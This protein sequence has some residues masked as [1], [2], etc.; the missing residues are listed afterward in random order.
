MTTSAARSPSCQPSRCS[1]RQPGGVFE[2]GDD[3]GFRTVG[4]HVLA[5][6]PEPVHGGRIAH[7]VP[8]CER[9]RIRVTDDFHLHERIDHERR[10]IARA[11]DRGDVGLVADPRPARDDLL[12]QAAGNNC[13]PT[14]PLA[15]SWRKRAVR[16]AKAWSSWVEAG[17]ISKK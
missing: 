8:L 14:R 7:R 1:S 4:H 3:R 16:S 12:P 5:D 17:D 15:A 10:G 2:G 11:R 6:E 9:T 13:N